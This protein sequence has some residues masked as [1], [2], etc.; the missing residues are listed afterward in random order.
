VKLPDEWYHDEVDLTAVS[1]AEILQEIEDHMPRSSSFSGHE[2]LCA[3]WDELKRR[4]SG[5]TIVRFG[6]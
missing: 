2:N 3:L 6:S 5:S 4:M 1:F